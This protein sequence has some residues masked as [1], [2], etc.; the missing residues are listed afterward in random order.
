MVEAVVKAAKKV[1]SQR[2]V[3]CVLIFFATAL[4]CFLLQ[5][6]SS[7]LPARAIHAHIDKDLSR[8]NAYTNISFIVAKDV[9]YGQ[10]DFSDSIMLNIAAPYAGQSIMQRAFSAT[11]YVGSS[12]IPAEGLLLRAKNW[13]L[14]NNQYLRYWCG[15]IVPLRFLLLFAD[16]SQIIVINII[17]L[18]ALTLT[19]VVLLWRRVG[20]FVALS[21]LIVLLLGGA[22]AVPFSLQFVGV[23]YIALLAILAILLWSKIYYVWSFA[24]ELFI[25]IGVLTVWI[26]F[27][28]APLVT[29][30][31]PLLVALLL[32]D[33]RRPFVIITSTVSWVM[34]YGTFWVMRWLLAIQMYPQ[35]G[36]FSSVSTGLATRTA[37]SESLGYKFAALGAN[38]A[39]L[40]DFPRVAFGED[41]TRRKVVVISALCLI[42]LTLALVW[43]INSFKP[44]F[45]NF[46]Y[47]FIVGLYPLVWYLALADH[48]TNHVWFT[49]RSLTITLF[50]LVCLAYELKP[51]SSLSQRK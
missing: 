31:L 26:D 45:K 7:A 1:W 35:S 8:F 17:L 21:F 51:F 28:T 47:C 36:I 32:D 39:M 5:I 48:S 14:A 10:D 20:P 44:S 13:D 43:L 30:G 24:P 9:K 41:V 46:A 29:L 3:R 4:C 34:S 25:I 27:L 22:L 42:L 19:N 23:F 37:Q 49:Y 38:F 50:A 15:F 2:V 33:E 16:Y 40:S 18:L 6:A 11:Y 12:P